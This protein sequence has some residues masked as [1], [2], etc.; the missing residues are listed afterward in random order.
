MA[1]KAID[2]SYKGYLFR[3]RLE[4][5]WAVF[6]DAVGVKWE[7]E[8]QGYDLGKAGFYLPDFWLPKNGCWLEVKPNRN[9]ESYLKPFALSE[10]SSKSVIVVSGAPGPVGGSD[11]PGIALIALW[12]DDSGGA[13][14]DMHGGF[15]KVENG[16][17]FFG[18]GA[19]RK[20]LYPTSWRRNAWRKIRWAN[21]EAPWE[22][23]Q[24][25]K[26]LNAARSSRFEHGQTPRG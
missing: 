26:A 12:I 3:S 20:D 24:V 9:R 16:V 22:S 11:S 17:L 21:P 15:Y 1:L 7:Y 25:K 6:L 18:Y 4:A 10:E 2:T 19:G 5:R 14:V 13:V 8:K 23:S